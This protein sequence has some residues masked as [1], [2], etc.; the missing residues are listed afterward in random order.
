M[1]LNQ[2]ER[3]AVFA[4]GFIIL[5]F[6]LGN[7]VISPYF[8]QMARMENTIQVQSKALEEMRVSKA[9]YNDLQKTI[10]QSKMRLTQREKGF[11]LFSFLDDLAGK[12]QIK[13]HIAYMKPSRIS[14]KNGKYKLSRVEMKLQDITMN[15]LVP[16]LYMIETSHN[17]VYI[18]RISISK[19]ETVEGFI[20]AVLQL[21]TYES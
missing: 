9:Q 11:T 21:V 1:K 4:T 13:G 5:I 6:I 10:A 20:N 12:V 19:T 15:Q 3:Y 14:Q 17:G 2:R 7:F 8:S 18:N 16:F